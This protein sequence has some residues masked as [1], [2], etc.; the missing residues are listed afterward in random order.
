MVDFEKAF[1]T[2]CWDFLKCC[3]D[4][5]GCGTNFKMWI[6]TLYRNIESCV[7][8][9]GYQSEYFHLSRG[10]RQGCPLIALLFLLA[11]EVV[12]IILR[13]LDCIHGINI[14]DTCIKLC[15]LADDMTLFVEDIDSICHAFS[16]FEE[17]YRYAGL[18]LNKA[19][20]KA[21]IIYNDGSLLQKNLGISWSKPPF[22]TLGTY[23]S[24]NFEEAKLLN[25]KDRFEKIKGI[26]TTWKGRALT[27]KGKITIIKSLIVPHILTL[28]SCLSPSE[29]LIADIDSLVTK[30]VWNHQKALIA[31]NTLIQPISRG[32]LKMPCIKKIV[33]TSQIM[34]VKRLTNPINA[35]WKQLSWFLLNTE[36]PYIFKKR[37]YYAIEK[38]PATEYYQDLLRNWYDLISFEPAR[39]CELLEEHL[40]QN[41]LFH[42]GGKWILNEYKELDN[43]GI[44][45]VK[46]FVKDNGIPY[47]RC[48]FQDKYNIR[49]DV[50]KYNKIT[51]VIQ[52]KLNGL[53]K[54]EPCF[55]DIPK[56][57]LKDLSKIK[58]RHVYNYYISRSYLNP[59]SQNKWVE[60]YPFLEKANWTQIYSL[61]SKIVKIHIG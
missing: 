30:F 41:D 59:S 27:L 7:T 57:C 53:P 5:Y 18:K 56:Q 8:N 12:A 34:W 9:N 58:S 44:N 35:K 54:I 29:K 60:Y 48:E 2:I 20:T 55:Y 36:P 39:L 43:K 37:L 10:I 6:A 13:N 15:Q 46:H 31:K 28:I 3:L 52:T 32:G 1:D 49:I 40:F 19:K 26:I 47:Q 25:I 14:K 51:S 16:V 45:L 24:T 21:I 61:P 17:F 33:Q 22:K 42:I 11:T 38:K 23:F 50:M 4:Y